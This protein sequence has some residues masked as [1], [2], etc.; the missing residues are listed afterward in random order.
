MSDEREKLDV[1]SPEDGAEKV[2]DADFEGH[3]LDVGRVDE[4]Q[5]DVG[6]VDSGQVD[7]GRVD[8]GQVDVG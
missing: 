4:G 1:G 8:S 7:V 2:E 6:R 3:R 5:V